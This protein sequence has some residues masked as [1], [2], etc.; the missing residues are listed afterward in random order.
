MYPELTLS[1]A[2]VRATTARLS[3]QLRAR[4]IDLLGVTKAVDGE[5]RV[6]RAMLAGG[7]VGLAD[8]RLPALE[9][10][11]V[12]GL[13]PL[14]LLRPP[15]PAEIA[16]CAE[17]ADRVLLSDPATAGAI[18]EHV[19][20]HPVQVL[21][22]VDLGDRREGILPDDVAA[23]AYDIDS[24]AGCDLA[25]I[26]A[27]FACLSGQ[28][29]TV[30]LFQ[31]AEDLLAEIAGL[32][33]EPLLSLG[34]TCCLHH[35]DGYQP[36]FPTEI[37]CGGGPLYGYDFVSGASLP[38]LERHDPLLTAVVLECYR[39]PPP[40]AG[41]T[42]CDALGHVPQVDLPAD[43]AWYALLNLGRRDCEPGGLRPLEEGARLAGA[44]SDVAVLI[45]AEPLAPGDTVDFAVDYDALVRAVTSPFVVKR[46]VDGDDDR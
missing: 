33:D 19:S 7:A 40:P 16:A 25:G 15:Q 14:T 22:T 26:A 39:K 30:S 32:C 34:G 17:F 21:L 27:N 42:G 18:G 12:A 46:F 37:R 20:E 29:P 11:A 41:A 1:L 4:G 45:V 38:G 9:R 43:D 3:A 35:L 2:A 6:G 31:A 5:P 36:R 13:G 23:A 44:T 8:S 28:L 10:L 24:T